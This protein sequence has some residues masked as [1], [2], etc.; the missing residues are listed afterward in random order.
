MRRLVPLLALLGAVGACGGSK[1]ATPAS[2][3][4]CPAGAVTVQMK[5]I[6]FAP[7]KTRLKVGQTVCWTNED[8][9]QHD[10][11]ADDGA[12]GSSLFGHG[13][14]FSWKA[15]KAGAI[16]YVCS[17]HPGMTGELDVSP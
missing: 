14:T 11:V 2:S 15:T 17:V 12:F 4:A 8:D 9:I 13:K 16:T 3:S 7:E 10:A 6:E 5:D 1:S